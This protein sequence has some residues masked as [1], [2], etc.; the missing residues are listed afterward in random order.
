MHTA[1]RS[2]LF[3]EYIF[4][5]I[6]KEVAAVERETGKKVLN[7]GPGSPDIPPSGMYMQKLHEYIDAK[8]SH[9]YPGYGAVPEFQEGLIQWYETR[10]GVPLEANE[11]FPLLGAKDAVAHLPLALLDE[12]DEVLMPNPGYPAYA[13]S[14]RMVGGVPVYYSVGEE[15]GSSFD[16][17]EIEEKITARTRYIWVNFPHNPTGRVIEKDDLEKL[18]ALARRKN[19]LIAYD[20]AY[21]EITFDGYRAPSILQIPQAKE[22]SIEIGSLSKTCSLAGYRIGY[23]VG[24]EDVVAALAKI[25]SQMDS[26]LSKPLQRLAGYT[27]VSPDAGWLRGALAVYDERRTTIG[28]FLRELGLSFTLPKGGLYIWAKIPGTEM[29]AEDFSMRLLR[30]RRILLTPGS[31]F[32]SN[33]ERYVRASIC[34]DITNIKEYSK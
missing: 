11:L 5:R 22:V 21:S 14:V 4:S 34:A 13:D 27:F 31:A 1:K 25:K 7:L 19:V 24:N 30:G 8:G 29:N 9:L 17:A 33:G 10:F 2:E 3:P 16:I 23:I 26:G 20:N 6:A 15:N 28:A 12:G 18:V 32:G